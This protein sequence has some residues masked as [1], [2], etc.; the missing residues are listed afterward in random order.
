ML[1]NKREH[2]GDFFLQRLVGLIVAQH[3]LR[4]ALQGFAAFTPG[5]GGIHLFAVA[6]RGKNGAVRA[7]MNRFHKADVRQHRLLMRGQR[8]RHQRRRADRV[9]NGVEQRQPG[10][11][12]NGQL[13]LRRAEGLPGGNVV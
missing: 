5:E 6:Q 12:A 10:E 3:Q 7:G 1:W 9:L 4:L 8:V 11:D 13:L 2:A